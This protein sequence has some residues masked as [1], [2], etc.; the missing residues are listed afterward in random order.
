MFRLVFGLIV[1]AALLFSADAD[2]IL[3][4]GKMITVDGKFTIQQAVAIKGEKIVAVGSDAALMKA[5]RGPGTRVV[6]L[7]G[8]TVLPGLVDSHDH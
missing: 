3:R 1:F 6:D 2:L 7:K 8:K 5:E 4:N